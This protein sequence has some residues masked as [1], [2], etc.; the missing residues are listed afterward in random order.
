[1]KFIRDIDWDNVFYLT[2]MPVWGPF[3]IVFYILGMIAG[4]IRCGFEDGI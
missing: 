3:Y 4:A 1:M 2:L